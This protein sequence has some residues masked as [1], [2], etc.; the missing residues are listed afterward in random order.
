MDGFRV[1]W[2]DTSRLVVFHPHDLHQRYE[3][4]NQEERSG[5]SVSK[6]EEVDGETEEATIVWM[7]SLFFGSR[8]QSQEW[9]R[10]HWV[11]SV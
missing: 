11:S 9:V 6:V 7:T 1:D 4:P 10:S 3:I 5:E 2:S 8:W